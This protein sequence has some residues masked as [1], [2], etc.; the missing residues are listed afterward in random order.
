M[1]PE[2]YLTLLILFLATVAFATGRW[3]PDA[4]AVVVLLALLLLRVVDPQVG[5]AGF[6]NP[7][8]VTVAAVFVLSAALERVGVAA[9]IGQQIFRLAGASETRLV[10]GFGLAAGLL[11]GVMNSL[12]A[13]AVLLPAAVATAREARVSPSKL[14]LPLA[15]GTRLGSVLTLIAGPSNLI[16]S[17]ALVAAGTRPFGL[18]EF[19]PLGGLF[20]VV[21]VAFMAF[22]G[23]RWLP[24]IPVHER[25]H[26]DPLIDL[27]RLRERLFQ[28][29]IPEG[30]PL[31]GKTIAQSEL[32]KSLGITVVSITRGS[33]QIV[34]PSRDE[35]LLS[36]DALVVEGRREE[37]LE[38]R[39]LPAAGLQLADHATSF[40]VESADVRV[41]EVILAPRSTLPGKTLR[42]IGFREKYGVTVLA[43]WREGRPRRTG[44]VDLPI[45][46]GDALL[47]QGERDRIRILRRDPDFLVLEL[48]EPEG[49]RMRRA[50]WAVLALAVMVAA[51]TLG[52][53][54]IAV[55]TLVAA[56]IVVAAGCVTVEEVYQAVD[57]RSLVFIG[58]MLPLGNA[59]TSTGAANT[60]VS[61]ALTVVGGTPGPA[62]LILLLSATVLNQLMPSVAATVL[63]API[64]L[65]IASTLGASPQAFLMAVV[66]GTGT[67]FT[68]VGSPVNLLVMGPGGYR[69][70][71]YVRVGLPLAI[72]LV[73]VGTLIIPQVWPLRP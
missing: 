3:R 40:Q 20:L 64:A 16:A 54:S 52:V 19:L 60:L 8:L 51:S 56:G 32:G 10:L 28:L 43:I 21:G 69:M 18:F 71:D 42:E 57:W 45:Q 66:A 11:S 65:H 13:V 17:E 58:A 67:T 73:A 30:S 44:L 27:Y 7:A 49:L 23:R 62:L 9:V 50:P 63:L 14:L 37:L 59:L 70:A 5:F 72:L 6:A 35:L 33:R 25:P 31:A 47:I 48:E 29:R 2:G 34:A 39:T 15:L 55:A 68:P 22:L 53:A 38:A 1:T 36:G 12:G 61:G 41:V 26:A 4:I 46:H 24:D